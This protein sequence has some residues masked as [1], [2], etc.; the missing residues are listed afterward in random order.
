MLLRMS[1]SSREAYLQFIYMDNPSS[2]GEMKDLGLLCIS[3]LKQCDSYLCNPTNY[4]RNAL[5]TGY[6]FVSIF[7]CFQYCSQSY[8]VTLIS[9]RMMEA[10]ISI[11][12]LLWLFISTTLSAIHLSRR[13]LCAESRKL[14]MRDFPVILVTTT[15]SQKTSPTFLAVTRESIVGFS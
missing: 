5:E 11:T 10:A 7:C 6:K 3:Y 9:F 13:I 15:V 8:T 1:I 14:T 2:R 4:A 12:S